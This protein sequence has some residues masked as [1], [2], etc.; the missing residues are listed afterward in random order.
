ME[1]NFENLPKAVWQLIDKVDKLEI[2]LQQFCKQPPRQ[3]DEK[4]LVIKEAAKYLNL[5]VPTIYSKVSRGE[6]PYFKKGKRLYFL[7]KNLE[8]FILS[9]RKKSLDEIKSSAIASLSL[10]RKGGNNG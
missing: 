10:K 1:S 6:L 2:V 3:D 8:E 7:K 9:G 5:S 4:P